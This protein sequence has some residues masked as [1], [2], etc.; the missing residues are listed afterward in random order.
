MVSQGLS[1]FF[2][3]LIKFQAEFSKE[4]I[5]NDLNRE[6]KVLLKTGD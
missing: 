2:V 3:K 1:L 6:F 5:D 4:T